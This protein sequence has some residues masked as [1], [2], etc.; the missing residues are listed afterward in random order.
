[1]KTR[2]HSTPF[3][4]RD[5]IITP[6]F[7]HHYPVPKPFLTDFPVSLFGWN[8]KLN[9]INSVQQANDTGQTHWD[10]CHIRL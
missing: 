3:S 6:S 4:H 7:D 8:T 5:N 1:M 2:F 10:W 9:Y